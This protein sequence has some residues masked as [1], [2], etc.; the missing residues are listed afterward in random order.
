MLHVLLSVLRG[1]LTNSPSNTVAMTG[2]RVTFRCASRSDKDRRKRWEY[3]TSVVDTV[4]SGFSDGWS[5]RFKAGFEIDNQ[6]NGQF[7]LVIKSVKPSDAG[8]Y[9]CLCVDALTTSKARAQLIVIG[10]TMLVLYFKLS[11]F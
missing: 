7:N 2:E 6:T 5:P 3:G 11:I 9:S 4:H 8:I 10:R 1:Q